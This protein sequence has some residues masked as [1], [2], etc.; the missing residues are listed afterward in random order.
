MDRQTDNIPKYID[1]FQ[2]KPCNSNFELSSKCI[3]T[4]NLNLNYFL[5]VGPRGGGTKTVCQ[6]ARLSQMTR[7]SSAERGNIRP[8]GFLV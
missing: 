5:F 8:L 7:K 4:K 1:T 2:Y 3:L 6:Y